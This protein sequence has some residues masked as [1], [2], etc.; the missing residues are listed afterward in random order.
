MGKDINKI[1]RSITIALSCLSL[2]SL[3]VGYTIAAKST[4][5]DREFYV[6]FLTITFGF[7]GAF[8]K[9]V[10]GIHGF[11]R[12]FHSGSIQHMIHHIPP[13]SPQHQ[14]KLA[15]DKAASKVVILS[16]TH[17]FHKDVTDKIPACDILIHC[18]DF[19]ML[20]GAAEVNDFVEW[21]GKLSQCK[22]KVLIAVCFSFCW[23]LFLL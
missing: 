12:T 23:C 8:V 3:G 19:T 14:S 4:A 15:N 1:R 5:G 16:D 22:H 10:G 20:G 11:K 9:L 18:G 17:M 6:T 13:I 2:T 21:F 7:L